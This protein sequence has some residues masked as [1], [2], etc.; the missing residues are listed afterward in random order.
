M[1]GSS[2]SLSTEISLRP[3][4]AHPAAWSRSCGPHPRGAAAPPPVDTPPV[5][6]MGSV[7]ALRTAPAAYRLHATADASCY[8][9]LEHN[10]HQTPIKFM[11]YVFFVGVTYAAVYISCLYSFLGKYVFAFIISFTRR[12]YMFELA[13]SVRHYQC[14]SP[15]GSSYFF[16]LQLL[17]TRSCFDNI[18]KLIG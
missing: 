10:K 2:P 16:H 7:A 1:S 18:Q 11:Q 13:A 15:P 12:L 6:A 3:L 8:L 4:D 14:P 17:S 5:S 9:H